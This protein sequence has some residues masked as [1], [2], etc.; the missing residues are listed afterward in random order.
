MLIFR[1]KKGLSSTMP[2]SWGTNYSVSL[3][4]LFIVECALRC[5]N[6]SVHSRSASIIRRESQLLQSSTEVVRGCGAQRVSMS[7]LIGV[8]IEQ[9]VRWGVPRP[10]CN[11][12]NGSDCLHRYGCV[13]SL[14]SLSFG[15]R[16]GR[17]EL[18]M[19]RMAFS[20]GG[21]WNNAKRHHE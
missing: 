10:F 11:A 18:K 4:Q 2:Q 13:A 12:E 14:V 5:E 19:P 1:K 6:L 16:H 20:E 7:A 3:V 9:I 15:W 21:Q 8:Y 17:S